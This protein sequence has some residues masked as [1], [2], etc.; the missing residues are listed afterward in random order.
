MREPALIF[1][2]G[3]VVA[4]FDHGRAY[5]SL[6]AKLGVEARLLRERIRARGGLDCFRQFECGCISPLDFAQEMMRIAE[7]TLPYEEFIQSWSDIFWPNETIAALL[8]RL[9]A[10]GYRMILGSNTNILHATHFRRQ[11][12]ATLAH[13][14]RLIFSYEVGCMKPD[15]GF[16]LACVEAAG[17]PAGS[18]VF[19]DD[20]EDNVQGAL[21]AGLR[22]LRYTDTEVLQAGLAALGFDVATET[23]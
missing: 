13:F 15:R 1:D 9:K 19:I 11:F 20:S 12:A 3:N 6:A 23:E 22:A 7:I 16:Y 4:H 18:C 14:D 2:F 17:V 8:P 5:E 21:G 10:G